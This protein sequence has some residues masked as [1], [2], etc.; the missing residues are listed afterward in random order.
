MTIS[1][2]IIYEDGSATVLGTY[3]TED[4]AED[5]V[6]Y[7]SEKYPHAYVDFLE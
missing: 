5:A 7:F 3:V 1:V 4:E 2:G 6:D